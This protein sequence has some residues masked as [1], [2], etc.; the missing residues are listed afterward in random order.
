MLRGREYSYIL[1]YL[2]DPPSPGCALLI[3]GSEIIQSS[4]VPAPPSSSELLLAMTGMA[5]NMDS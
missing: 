2:D 1:L 4:S 3:L 5:A